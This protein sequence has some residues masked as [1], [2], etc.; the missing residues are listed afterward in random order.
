M[1]DGEHG[2]LDKEYVYDGINDN[3]QYLATSPLAQPSIPLDRTSGF[4]VYGTWIFWQFLAEYLGGSAPD[5]SIVR[6][7]WKRA[8]GSEVGPDMYST[9]ALAASVGARTIDG[10]RWRLRWAF[11]DF[12][13]WNAR[14]AT[15]YDEGG[16]YPSAP[17]SRSR[18]SRGPRHP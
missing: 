10:T 14:P 17:V 5:A 18:P 12:A 2:D 6:A 4:R 3:R 7:V 13:A 1:A 11:A 16:V 15:F 8:D 9:K